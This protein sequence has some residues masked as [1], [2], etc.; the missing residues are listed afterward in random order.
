MN[1]KSNLIKWLFI[2]I[3]LLVILCPA[4]KGEIVPEEAEI[5]YDGGTGE[6]N[7]PYLISTPE[8]LKAI[9]DSTINDKSF[10]LVADIDLDPNLPGNEIITDSSFVGT[11]G[12]TLD[13]NDH[14]ISNMVI[15]SYSGGRNSTCVGFFSYLK[16]HAVVQ[17]LHLRNVTIHSAGMYAGALAGA[18][19]GKILRCSVTGNIIGKTSVGG[20]VGDNGGDIVSCSAFCNVRTEQEGYT[21][22]G[23]LV[24]YNG[25]FG[26]ISNCYAIGTVTGVKEV[27]GLVG[28]NEHYISNCYAEC[29]VTGI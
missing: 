26:Y 12:G 7:D 5:Q 10:K 15:E 22:A 24:G 20:L 1:E 14:I 17:G 6:A 3:V 16:F 8:Q 28:M 18:N 27:G 11:F 25:L 13:G 4:V 21:T 29:T 19:E 2:I 23:G 9:G